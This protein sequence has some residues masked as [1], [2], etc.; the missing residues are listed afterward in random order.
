LTF[1]SFTKQFLI[2]S[3]ISIIF[4]ISFNI[5]KNEFG[6]FGKQKNKNIRIHFAEKSSKYLLS[7]NYIPNNFNGI[8]VGPSLS[9]QMM[10]TKKLSTYDIYNM[11][12]DGGNISE[13][14]FAI[15]NILKY[16]KIKLF[17]ICL[18]P[19]ITKNSG[20]KSS[21]INNKEYLGTLGSLFT[22][23]FYLHRLMNLKKKGNQNI[24]F[25]SYWGYTDN[26]YDKKDQN[27][28][29]NINKKLKSLDD[30]NYNIDSLK[31]DKQAYTELKD[32]LYDVRKENIKIIAY[33][34]PRPKRIFEH[35][36][37]HKEYLKYRK[38]IDK[39]LKYNID[40]VIDF[41]TNKYNYIRDNDNSY[42]DG[43]HLSRKGA[44]K[45][46]K[47]LNKNILKI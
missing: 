7:F 15:D 25:D 39:L 31:I 41:E 19:Y 24:Y 43:G 1:K 14:K 29:L 33:Y 37:Y 20:R 23:K 42:S 11:S 27:A 18:D 40:T 8:L 4:V 10:D 21:Q 32:I 38:K 16:G 46:L 28:T 22:V 44:N 12:M 34:Y 36:L 9:D 2:I 3:V 6:L 13:L 26:E 35:P 17:I 5:Y 30:R 47:V 45:L